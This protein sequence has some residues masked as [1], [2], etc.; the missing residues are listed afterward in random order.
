MK[1]RKRAKEN[2]PHGSMIGEEVARTG[3][4]DNSLG[5][6]YSSR[7]IHGQIDRIGIKPSFG[8]DVTTMLVGFGFGTIWAHDARAF[9]CSSIGLCEGGWRLGRHG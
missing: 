6:L 5:R 2:T 1:A 9:F 3:R 7:I 8:L 4:S